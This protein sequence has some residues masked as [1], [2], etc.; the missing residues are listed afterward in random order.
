[1]LRERIKESN[2]TWLCSNIFD[3]AT[4]QV[5]AGCLRKKIVT[6]DGFRVGLFGVCTRSTL[7]LS[8]PGKSVEFKSVLDSAQELVTELREQDLCEVIIALTHLSI[9]EDR[10]LARKIHGI[11]CMLG[12]HDHGPHTQ[13]QSNCFIHKAGHDGHYLARIDLH[14][15]RRTTNVL[16]KIIEKTKIFPEWKMILNRGV[17]PNP[18]VAQVVQHYLDELPKDSLEE[19]G[20]ADTMLDSSTENVRSKETSMGNLTADI[21]REAFDTEIGMFN[22]GGIR[23]DRL[24]DPGYRITRGDIYREFPF[25]NGAAMAKIKGK[26]LWEVMESVLGVAGTSFPYSCTNYR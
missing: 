15:E 1:V 8:A 5:L 13:V 6:F 3:T 10:E 19:I 16:G 22:G 23:G 18:T 2:F 11:D 25:P 4:G 24:Y 14:V 9:A 21:L 26:H 17:V 20:I 12:G 7:T